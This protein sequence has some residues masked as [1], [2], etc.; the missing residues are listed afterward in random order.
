MLNLSK[1]DFLMDDETLNQEDEISKPKKA[2][3]TKSLKRNRRQR[4]IKEQIFNEL[5][6][7]HSLATESDL[8]ELSS[9]NILLEKLPLISISDPAI[10]HLEVNAGDVIKIKRLNEIIGDIYYFRKVINDD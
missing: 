9:N 3:K 4:R 8:L 7:E 1:Q 6:P 5:I 10:R 2:T